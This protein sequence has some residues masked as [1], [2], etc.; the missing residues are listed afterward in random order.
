MNTNKL[1]LILGWEEN[2]HIRLKKNLFKD[3]EFDIGIDSFA[4]CKEC[5]IRSICM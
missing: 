3:K 5:G 1:G 4:Q 2:W